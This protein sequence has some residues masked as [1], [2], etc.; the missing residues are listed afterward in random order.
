MRILI[1][2]GGSGGHIFPALNVALELKKHGHDIMFSGVL[3][4]ASDIIR[5]NG[6]EMV[7]LDARGF[8]T[9]SLKSFCISSFC[10]LKAIM[11][12]KAIL[13]RFDPELVF[14]FGGYGA[15]PVVF[16]AALLRY[17][18][19]IH[20]QNVVPGKANRVLARMVDKIAI[21][22]KESQEY[23]DPAK[24]V[25]TGC[26][27]R[28]NDQQGTRSELTGKFKLEDNKYTILVLGGSQG[29]HRI[30][31]VFLKTISLLKQHFD[32]QVIH[33][34]GKQDYSLV[35]DQYH[36]LPIRSSVHEFLEEMDMAYKSADLVIS[37]AGAVTVTEIGIFR[38]PSILI[39][40]PLAGG[41]QK[42]NAKLLSQTELAIMIE[43]KELTPQF[44]NEA[45]IDL[46][47]RK[48]SFE[49]MEKKMDE[50]FP[51]DAAHRLA[52]EAEEFLTVVPLKQRLNK[53]QPS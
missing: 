36:T 42:E 47:R 34:T 43:E 4:K 41:H 16:T 48:V 17:P 39:P 21:S 40:Y 31:E 53:K 24:I 32:F 35:R 25:L 49:N 8:S 19:L 26:P 44:L 28:K 37:R 12:S 3:D 7:H 2:T 11:H 6:F 5:R 23:F 14:G 52:R 45:I 50:I 9:N 20:E 38:K 18:T 15:F 13:K 22:F 29:S 10:M 33:L 27:C 30:N 51:P 1:A 46:A